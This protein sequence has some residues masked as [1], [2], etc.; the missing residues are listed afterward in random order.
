MELAVGNKYLI[1][2]KEMPNTFR[3][4]YSIFLRE[5]I[6]IFIY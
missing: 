6:N 1:F 3:N 5:L 4:Y 2:P